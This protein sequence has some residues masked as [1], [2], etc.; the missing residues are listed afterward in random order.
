MTVEMVQTSALN[1]GGGPLPN[2][3]A[4]ASS[5]LPS[6][7]HV[8]APTTNGARNGTGGQLAGNTALYH[9]IKLQVRHTGAICSFNFTKTLTTMASALA[10]WLVAQMLTDFMARVVF[11]YMKI[12]QSRRK[13][14]YHANAVGHVDRPELDAGL[15]EVVPVGDNGAPDI[16]GDAKSDVGN[17]AD[18]AKGGDQ[19]SAKPDALEQQLV[20]LRAK[21]NGGPMPAPSDVEE[22]GVPETPTASRTPADVARAAVP[23]HVQPS[24]EGSPVPLIRGQ[25]KS[26]TTLHSAMRRVKNLRGF[27]KH[28]EKIKPPP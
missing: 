5:G 17:P 24:E 22:G 11:G 2:L 1:I 8:P 3:T 13:R 27:A 16:G 9:G 15:Q 28:A 10:L 26:K 20:A 4:A 19:A 18:Q 23:R 25:L 12:K 14:S 7:N 6:L 21:Q